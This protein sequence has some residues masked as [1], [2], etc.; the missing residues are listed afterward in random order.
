M[1]ED[2]NQ[3]CPQLIWLTLQHSLFNHRRHLFNSVH[4]ALPSSKQTRL[5]CEAVAGLVT[6]FSQGVVAQLTLRH[7]K[8]LERHIDKDAEFGFRR[9]RGT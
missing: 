2:P 1:S 5:S 9:P 4:H 7:P 3:H 6:L 8:M